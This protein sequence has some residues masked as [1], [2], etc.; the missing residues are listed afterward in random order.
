K[1]GGSQVTLIIQE[2]GATIVP[3]PNA[4]RKIA[5]RI[6]AEVEQSSDA[7]FTLS[8]YFTPLHNR[9]LATIAEL[10]ATAIPALCMNTG[11]FGDDERV[12]ATIHAHTKPA[13]ACT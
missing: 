2:P 10:Q 12:L 8:A 11:T 6:I 13:W 5:H 1:L 3:T 4:I 9:V 7:I